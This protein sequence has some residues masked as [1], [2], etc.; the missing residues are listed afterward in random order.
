MVSISS[1]M[2]TS[3]RP[4]DAMVRPIVAFLFQSQA[5]C[6]PLC[7]EVMRY[8]AW[9]EGKVS[10]SSEM[11]TS[12]RPRT[13]QRARRDDS[14]FQS[15]ARCI[16]LCDLLVWLDEQ[17]WAWSFNLKRDAYLFATHP[18]RHQAQATMKFQSQAR[19]IPLCD[20]RSASRGC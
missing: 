4:V 9:N 20:R 15:Q 10:I 12:L 6:I 17:F 5:R 14:L 3:L 13:R 8:Q 18:A 1:E 19:C 11:H 7:D 2:H 16:P